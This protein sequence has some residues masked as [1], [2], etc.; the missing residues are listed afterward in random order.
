MMKKLT[1]NL[2][3]ATGLVGSHLLQQLLNDDRFEQV[4]V[5]SRRATGQS[6]PKLNEQLV[7]FDEM[8]EWASLING[9]VLFSTLG[10]TLKKAGSKEK[11]FVIDYTYQYQ[12]AETAV[13]NGVA[14]FVLVSSAGANTN[15]KIF[16]SRMKGELDEAV[17][18]LDF[19]KIIIL[20]PSILDGD[21]Q[22][23]RTAEKI[24]IKV[25]RWLTQYVFKKYRPIHAKTVA[26]AMINSIFNEE[27]TTDYLIFELDEVEKLGA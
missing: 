7:N 17:K 20:R 8:T 4:R 15:S 5:F 6:H 11:Q 26:R 9:D 10:T 24:G 19:K 12:A 3:G 25:M 13:K 22:E 21:R 1:A 14:D 18:G 23:K 16:Y 27:L 2:I